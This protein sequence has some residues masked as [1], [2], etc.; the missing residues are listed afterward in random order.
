MLR[1]QIAVAEK[2]VNQ[3]RPSNVDIY[4]R[5]VEDVKQHYEE[6]LQELRE[7]LDNLKR[8]EN[9]F[10]LDIATSVGRGESL[11]EKDRNPKVLVT[12]RNCG[13]RMSDISKGGFFTT[14]HPRLL[15]ESLKTSKDGDTSGLLKQAQ[16]LFSDI[17]ERNTTTTNYMTPPS[18]SNSGFKLM[19]KAQGVCTSKQQ[20]GSETKPEVW[21]QKQQAVGS[22]PSRAFG[23]RSGSIGVVSGNRSGVKS[24]KPNF[25]FVS[26]ASA[27]GIKGA[28]K[29][30]T[31]AFLPVVVTGPEEQKTKVSDQT[32]AGK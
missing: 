10:Y 5:K 25:K 4:M 11:P 23:P 12:E 15:Q 28:S 14:G 31:S 9:N 7:E 17:P 18:S 20:T 1:V 22:T 26:K 30:K 3:R 27:G 8:E 21:R 6:H 32:D 16:E 24:G 13:I 19:D 29:I 2:S